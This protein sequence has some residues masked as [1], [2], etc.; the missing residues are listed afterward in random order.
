MARPGAMSRSLIHPGAPKTLREI[1]AARQAPSPRTPE[2][3]PRVLEALEAHG[4]IAVGDDAWH[5]TVADLDVDSEEVYR[6][7]WNLTFAKRATRSVDAD[8][9]GRMRW[10]FTAATG[11]E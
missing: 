1:A 10:R 9:L 11:L 8:E 7:L 2:L 6:A 3:A 4:S 5:A